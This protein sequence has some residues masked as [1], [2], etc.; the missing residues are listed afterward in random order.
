MRF[1]VDYPPELWAAMPDP[2]AGSDELWI[3]EQRAAFAGG[4]FADRGELFERAAREALARRRA[5][6]DTSLLFRPT[7]LPMTG[8]V[9]A[10]LL[11]DPEASARTVDDW[12]PDPA[13]LLVDPAVSEFETDAFEH[14]FR[15]AYVLKERFA[16]GSPK[17]GFVYGLI[18]AGIVGTVFSEP[19]IQEV[20]GTMQLYTDPVV[21]SLRTAA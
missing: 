1:A 5:G 3:A 4:P 10:V 8:V 17:T 9:H 16:D 18:G 14:G 7:E 2:A 20:T 19:A 6:V 15:I 13:T 21:G 12:L 11:S